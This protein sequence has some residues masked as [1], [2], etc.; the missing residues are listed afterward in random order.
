MLSVGMHLRS[1]WKFHSRFGLF[2]LTP[3]LFL[4]TIQGASTDIQILNLVWIQHTFSL[5]NLPDNYDNLPDN[6]DN[7]AL[8]QIPLISKIMMT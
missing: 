4:G 2:T 1:V 5:M 7:E 8:L 6:Y 3:H